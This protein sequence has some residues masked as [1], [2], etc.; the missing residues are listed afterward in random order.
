MRRTASMSSRAGRKRLRWEYDRRMSFVGDA[1]SAAFVCWAPEDATLLL[2]VAGTTYSSS[3]VS[4]NTGDGK[5]CCVGCCVWL[6]VV[7]PAARREEPPT[8][9]TSAAAAALE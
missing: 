9:Y 5:D 6:V 7:L 3:G 8:S 1:S 2:R 4:T